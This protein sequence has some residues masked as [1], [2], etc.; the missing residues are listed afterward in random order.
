MSSRWNHLAER[1]SFR[2]TERHTAIFHTTIYHYIC[3]RRYSPWHRSNKN[4]FDFVRLEK[5]H[6][7]YV[8]DGNKGLVAPIAIGSH[9][10]LRKDWRMCSWEF[11]PCSPRW[12]H[13]Q[14][15]T[16]LGCDEDEKTLSE[17]FCLDYL[18]KIFSK[19]HA[20]FW[21]VWSLVTKNWPPT[22]TQRWLDGGFKYFSCSPL[23]G[24]DSHFD[25][26]FSDGL[27]PPTRWDE[28]WFLG[29]IVPHPPNQ[30]PGELFRN[31]RTLEHFPSIWQNPWHPCVPMDPSSC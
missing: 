9:V 10:W 23:F 21:E 28:C 2:W 19:W 18:R 20:I 11:L 31:V 24:E 25:S 6:P 14:A 22:K 29:P 16:F 7:H 4:K 3:S 8:K 30:G 13:T 5:I 17:C 15:S 12:G 27:K 1:T 26:Y